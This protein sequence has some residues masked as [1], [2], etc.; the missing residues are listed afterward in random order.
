MR[1]KHLLQRLAARAAPADITAPSAAWSSSRQPGAVRFT[2]KALSDWPQCAPKYQPIRHWSG[3]FPGIRLALRQSPRHPAWPCITEIEKSSMS[4]QEIKAFS[5]QART[6]QDLGEK[7]KACEKVRELITLGKE[8]G[9]GI[10]EDSLYPP[11]E[12]QFTEDQLSAK[13]VKALLRA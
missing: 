11:N 7:L 3:I 4:I 10:H 6:D 2:A 5:S 13:L 12:P 8:Y 9:F 1:E